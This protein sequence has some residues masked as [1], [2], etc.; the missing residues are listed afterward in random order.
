MKKIHYLLVIIGYLILFIV[1]QFACVRII[2]RFT[3]GDEFLTCVSLMSSGNSA[4]L[5]KEVELL[6]LSSL[7]SDQAD[8]IAFMAGRAALNIKDYESARKYF[9]YCLDHYK[10]LEDHVLYYLSRAYFLGGDAPA[11]YTAARR[12]IDT[13][14]DSVWFA[15]AS[16]MIGD[17]YA[18]MGDYDKALSVYEAFLTEN[19]KSEKYPGILFLKGRAMEGVG[20]PNEALTVYKEVWIGYP[21][22]R[23]AADAFIGISRLGAAETLT[24]SELKRRID[25][26]YA[27]GDY[28]GVVTAAAQLPA[29]L[30]TKIKT[31]P[32]KVAKEIE[33]IK[34]K[35][36][37]RSFHYE[38][39]RVIFEALIADPG[40]LPRAELLYW[41][42]RTYD[43]LGKDETAVDYY[44]A[45]FR[46]YPTDSLADDGLFLAARTLEEMK[47]Y[48]EAIRYYQTYL[49]TYSRGEE[50]RNVLW[51][52]G[53][54]YYVKKDYAQAEEY[55]E[56]MAQN[57]R[58]KSE[59]PQYLYWK[60]RA[61]ER[62][63]RIAEAV[64]VFK[65]V[66][67]D[68][69]TTYYSYQSE[70]RLKALG[71]DVEGI[72]IKEAFDE[73]FWTRDFG[74]Y[75]AFTSDARITSHLTRALE[76]MTM[77]MDAEAGVEIELVVDRC[78]GDPDLLVEVA[79]LLRYSGDYYTPILMAA[80]HFSHFFSTYQPGKNDVYWQMRYPEG[81]KKEVERFAEEFGVEPSFVYAVIREE[82]LF[83]PR[84]VSW[85]G[86]VG[87]MQIM[88]ATGKSIA[89]QLGVDDFAVDDLRDYR[90][91]VRFGVY[92]LS[93]L[94]TEF[95]GEKVYALCGYNA[96]PGNAHRWIKNR[97]PEMEMDEF[98]EDIP[99][100]E[101]R[102][103]VKR[104]LN[105]ESIY[106]AVYES[107]DKG[108]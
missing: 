76:L 50:V 48:D 51:N 32:A 25:N 11:A 101:T 17:Y 78:V 37:F 94:M 83:Q 2:P 21:T 22:N 35:A 87:L 23:A 39:A 16:V 10:K 98:I 59:Y 86:A 53:W 12:L 63:G 100:S 18:K 108:K 30:D 6:D 82:S 62:M 46:A 49:N 66:R 72:A 104:I 96:G 26:L 75:D 73:S 7:P 24:L 68:Y 93:G 29:L 105:T 38:N 20:K 60:G 81:Y 45:L 47:R 56:R 42:A 15:D 34:A 5:V 79:R 43:R 61:L 52:I 80:R 97:D 95:E 58:G 41:R 90:T 9:E 91:N 54:L 106:R 85:A 28:E 4:A 3:P 57:Y 1:F 64:D 13:Y 70:R 88:P 36:Y 27:A 99:F 77:N 31:L 40:G 107:D 44:L 103:Y 65:A 74:R 89:A 14:P 67:K 102:A 69:I 92:Y 33:Y 19:K 55:F 71:V 8:K 84:V